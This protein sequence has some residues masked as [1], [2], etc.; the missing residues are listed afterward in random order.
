MARANRAATESPVRTF[1]AP[2]RAF[3]QGTA[4]AVCRSDEVY[5]GFEIQVFGQTPCVYG[6]FGYWGSFSDLDLGA[7][8]ATITGW[9]RCY[10]PEPP[11]VARYRYDY[12]VYQWVSC[13]LWI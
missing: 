7:T 13:C 10:T 3:L 4:E 1:R 11:S 2:R 5:A 6:C 12:A 8:W 9:H